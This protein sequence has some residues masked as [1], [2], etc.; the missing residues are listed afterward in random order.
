MP[1]LID[2][3][4]QSAYVKG[5]E[6]AGLGLC[7][8]PLDGPAQVN[9]AMRR[10]LGLD[11]EEGA[12]ALDR[13]LAQFP[14]GDRRELQ[15]AL[16]AVAN[17]SPP[18]RIELKRPPGAGSGGQPTFLSLHLMGEAGQDGQRQLVMVCQNNSELYQLRE[19]LSVTD[20]ATRLH[21]RAYFNMHL[22]REW[23]ISMRER[24]DLSLML[25]EAEPAFPALELGDDILFQ[26][27]QV[28]NSAIVR[29]ADFAARFTDTWMA[30]L[31][32]RTDLTGARHV[33]DR[34]WA[35]LK[36]DPV[37]SA[38]AP[39]DRPIMSLGVA[40]LDPSAT[41]LGYEVLVSRAEAALHNCQLQGGAC[42]EFWD[43]RMPE[44]PRDL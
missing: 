20:L 21:T 23:R 38:L 3:E 5:V 30:V 40:S 37:I 9:E 6:N 10:L 7:W 8:G 34:L 27:G 25:L 1:Q 14:A 43:P 35:Y 11:E 26:L 36:A 19:S 12:I 39:A 17:G 42:V 32:P 2:T 22:E 24:M 41:A 13:M 29:P 44:A 16:D 28:L 18:F 4:A 15:A 31:L 33:A